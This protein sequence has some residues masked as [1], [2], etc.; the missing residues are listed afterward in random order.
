MSQV[1]ATRMFMQQ[2]SDLSRAAIRTVGLPIT[3]E[4]NQ[5]WVM[6]IDMCCELEPAYPNESMENHRAR[7]GRL[8]KEG[9]YLLPS[10]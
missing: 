4:T 8:I 2:A 10:S 3:A 7:V 9:R 1:K 5:I 6:A